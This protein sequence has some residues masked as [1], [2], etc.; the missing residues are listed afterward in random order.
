M[1]CSIEPWESASNTHMKIGSGSMTICWL[2]SFP[3]SAPGGH[4]RAS[5]AVWD[6]P[7]T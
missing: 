5:A 4:D 6:F 7:D 2:L 1:K 3:M